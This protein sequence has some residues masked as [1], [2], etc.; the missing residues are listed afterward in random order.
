[1][2]R[3]LLFIAMIVGGLS[4]GS[5]TAQRACFNYR[6]EWSSWHSTLGNV[7]SNSTYSAISLKTEG[8]LE[9][10]SFWISNYSEPSKDER[11]YH[12]KNNVW[13]EYTGWVEYQVNDSY[14]TALEFSKA[15]QFVIP[16]PRYDETPTITRKAKCKIKIAPYKKH[17]EVYNIWF[18]DIGVGVCI[19]D[20]KFNFK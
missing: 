18:D 17:P 8:G 14:P 10:F 4:I 7:S 2:K 15:S 20:L 6:G 19:S 16:N 3:F 5:I 1:M 13:Y 12:E 11:K 9:Y